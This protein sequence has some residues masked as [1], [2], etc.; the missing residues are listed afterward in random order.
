MPMVGMDIHGLAT[1]H[2]GVFREKRCM[3]EYMYVN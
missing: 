2:N 3:Y 1:L